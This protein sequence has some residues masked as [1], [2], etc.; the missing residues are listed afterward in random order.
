[1]KTTHADQ[2]P[3]QTEEYAH[4]DKSQTIN[5]GKKDPKNMEKQGG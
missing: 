1:M 5:E 4:L 3:T 2:N